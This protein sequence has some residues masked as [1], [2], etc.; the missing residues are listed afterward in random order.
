MADTVFT[1]KAMLDA[2][3]VLRNLKLIQAEFTAAGRG[4]P[5]VVQSR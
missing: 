3:N 4:V 2:S 1:Y 5:E